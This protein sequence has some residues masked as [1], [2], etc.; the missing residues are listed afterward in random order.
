MQVAINEPAFMPASWAEVASKP[1]IAAVS[2]IV[3][4]CLPRL[5]CAIANLALPT[6]RCTALRLFGATQVPPNTADDIAY[7]VGSR[8]LVP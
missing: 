8:P 3:Y 2:L 5:T 4:C 7:V 1:G 6:R